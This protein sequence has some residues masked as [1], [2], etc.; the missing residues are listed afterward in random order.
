[1]TTRTA[2]A[3]GI[4]AVALLAG[5][6]VTADRLDIAPLNA[7]ATTTTTV[8]A[9]GCNDWPGAFTDGECFAA[10]SIQVSLS[11]LQPAVQFCK[12][13]AANPGEWQR[14]SD[15]AA[16]G[17]QA[18]TI[19]TWLGGSIL[20]ELQGYFAAHAPPFTLPRTPLPPNACGGKVLAAPVIG[21]VT[22]GQTD[23]TVT[24][25]TTP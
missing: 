10:G 7:T 6:F 20:D 22:P 14:L 11:N 17:T 19:V 8:G 13:K 5:G 4:G 23:V 9:K 18:Q 24:V 16:T 15:Y 1:M 2:V 12:W 3:A 21:A 25:K